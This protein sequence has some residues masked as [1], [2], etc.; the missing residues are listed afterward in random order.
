MTNFKLILT[1]L[2]I[3]LFAVNVMGWHSH[4]HSH[5]HSHEHHHHHHGHGYGYGGGY[6]G[7]NYGGGYYPQQQQQWPF[8]GKK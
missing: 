4:S 1:L 8:F 7:G 6:Y 5:S 3:G 2:F